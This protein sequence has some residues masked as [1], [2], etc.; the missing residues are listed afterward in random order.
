[1]SETDS[2]SY[3]LHCHNACQRLRE[4]RELLVENE[5][6]CGLSLLEELIGHAS[7]Y[8]ES[9]VKMDL[10]KSL[11]YR[12][13]TWE[14]QEKLQEL[15]QSRRIKHNSLISQ[16]CIL[17]RYLF[18]NYSAGEEVPYGGVYSLP[19]HTLS[20]LDRIAVGDW[21]GYLILGLYAQRGQSKS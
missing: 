8:I 19:L 5:D 9:V 15:D 4:V 16:L 20:P 11:K 21:A 12:L 6:R 17:N 3:D 18:K 10:P 1:M 14:F 13:E 7:R 2:I